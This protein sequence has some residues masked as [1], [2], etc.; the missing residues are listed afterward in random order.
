MKVKEAMTR[1]PF[2][3]RPSDS[4]KTVLDTLAERKIS[5]CPVV[6]SKGRVL[7]VI[8][9]TDILRIIDVHSGIQKPGTD[10]FSLVLASIR[11]ESYDSMKTAL[12]KVMN[13]KIRDFMA[14]DVVSIDHEEDIYTAARLMNKHDVDR[15]PVVKDDK[16]VGILTRWDVIRALEK[17]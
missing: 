15:L 11:S 7:G 8:T 10:L 3:L 9:Q 16:L 5:G 2:S 13:L 12:K 17:L 1:S 6:D 4:I 14:K